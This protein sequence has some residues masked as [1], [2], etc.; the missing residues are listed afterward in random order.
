[1]FSLAILSCILW[2]SVVVGEAAPSIAISINTSA[3]AALSSSHFTC[4]N[5]DASS[6]RGFFERDLDPTKPY[7]KQIAK[8]AAAIGRGQAMQLLRWGGT[9]NDQLSYCFNGGESACGF[10]PHPMHRKLNETMWR[11]LLDFT[12]AASAKIIVG[13]AV[14]KWTGCEWNQQTDKSNCTLWNSTNARQLLSWTIA[15]GYDGLIYALELGNEVDGMYTG[16]G[17][18]RNLQVLQQL[19]EELWPDAATRPLLLGPDAAHQQSP[20]GKPEPRDAYV[21]DFFAACATLKVPIAGATLHKY[22]EVTTARDTNAT[23]LDKTKARL[24]AYSTTVDKG[25]HSVAASSGLP[26][27]RIWGGEVGPHNGGVPPCDHTSM[28][29]ATFA[30]SLWYVDGLATAATLGYEAICR[31]DLI[32][33]DY[34]LLD[35]A[36]GLPLPDFWSSMLFSSL[37]SERVLSASAASGAPSSLRVYAHCSNAKTTT[38]GTP[39]TVV[40]LNLAS[41]TQ[42]VQLP[43]STS[44]FHMWQ[45]T[46][47]SMPGMNGTSSGLGGTDAMLNGERLTLGADGEVPD[48]LKKGKHIS[49]ATVSLPPTSITFV[50]IDG[51]FAT[52]CK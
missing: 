33:A 22:I 27:P 14:P 36:T 47:S 44:A 51:Y 48:L 52:A 30:D 26:P 37:T 21:R 40:I 2:A 8:Q 32:G 5:I 1:M 20:G 41:T 23:F 45:M 6:N 16:E 31:Q 34:G 10:E 11:S 38:P 15:N 28:R 12:K 19:T 3:V 42:S 50:V 49:G 39:I 43:S 17:Q 7:G 13:L 24:S 25:W 9:G 35:C 18:A 4:W 29:W 46:P